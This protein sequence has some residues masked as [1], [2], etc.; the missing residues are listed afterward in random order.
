MPLWNYT[1][2]AGDA[3]RNLGDYASG[4]VTPTIRL[5]VTG[6]A[7]SGKTVFIAALVHNLI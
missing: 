6:L 1:D 3:V 2:A 5:G 4:L 7:R